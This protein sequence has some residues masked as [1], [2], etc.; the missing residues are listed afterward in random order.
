[1]AEHST[2]TRRLV[3]LLALTLIVLLALVGV[4][5]DRT[6][7]AALLDDPG[8]RLASIRALIVGAFLAAAVLGLAAVS[9]VRRSVRRSVAGIT[10]SVARISEGD[11]DVRVSAEGAEELGELA[12]A[13]NRMAEDLSARIERER[14]DREMRDSILA[15]MEEGVVLIQEAEVQYVNPAARELLG[16][17]PRE[18]RAITP[19]SLRRLVEAVLATGRLH[20][21]EIQS[22]PPPRVVRATAMA[23]ASD[24]VL[25]VLRDVTEP[26]RVEAMRRDFVADASHELKTPVASIHAAAETIRGSLVDDPEAAGRFAEQLHHDAERLW[27]IISD[28]LDLSRLD[29]VAVAESE[30]LRQRADRAGITL[31][32]S[33]AEATVRGDRK[34]LGL[35][36]AN[37]LDNAIRY[38]GRGGEVR[39]RVG[40]ADGGAEVTVEDTGVGIPSRDL[41]RIFERFYRVD[42]ARSRDTGGTGLGL[43]IARHVAEEHGGRIE[44]ESELGRGSTFRVI[45]PAKSRQSD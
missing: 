10:D 40:S 17:A 15:A 31:R 13:L 45:L 18:A 34:D 14:E 9:V 28:L 35:L 29:A 23:V 21:E 26:R 36:V 24:R 37:L 27:R 30:R 38:T 39:L 32:V 43:S 16:E 25:L 8:A 44:V 3:A 42:R 2:L 11:L 33:A 4:V 19:P 22:G 6:I 7:R 1:M 41:P 5:L 12:E 20:H